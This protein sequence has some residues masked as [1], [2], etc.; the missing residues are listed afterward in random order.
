MD[1]ARTCRVPSGPSRPRF[2]CSSPPHFRDM[3]PQEPA[4]FLWCVAVSPLFCGMLPLHPFFVVCCR[5]NPI[6]W[7][8]A[9]A[10]PG[11]APLHEQLAGAEGP[12][13]GVQ[14]TPRAPARVPGGLHC[15]SPAGRVQQPNHGSYLLVPRPT[16]CACWMCPATKSQRV[17]VGASPHPLRL[18]D[19][20]SALT[21]PAA[22]PVIWEGGRR[23][24]LNYPWV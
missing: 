10:T 1:H 5:C 21:D 24:S 13:R 19:V 2:F 6:L 14:Q 18:L 9:A 8:F 17:S 22:D 7:R 20:S 3:L 15:P 16:F 12:G 4:L 11:A 23:P